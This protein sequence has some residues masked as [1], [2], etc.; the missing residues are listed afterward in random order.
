[1]SGIV[2][3]VNLGGAPVDGD[4]V[5][6]LTDFMS[7]RGPDA[8]EVW[9]DRHVGL[10]HTLLRTTYE[11]EHESQPATLDGKVW[12]VADARLDARSELVRKLPSSLI[13]KSNL[14]DAELILYAYETWGGECINYL[15]GDFA[16]AIWDCRNQRLFCA[17]DHLGVKPFFYAHVA[18]SFIFSNTLNAL[19]LDR[20]VSDELNEEAI[21]DYLLFGLNQDLSTTTFRDIRRLAA[22]HTLTVSD[23]NVKT[24]CYWTPTS[25]REV[26]FQDSQSYVERFDE[27]LSS[28]VDD[29]LRSDRAAISM[30]GGLDSTSIAAVAHERLKNANSLR[31]VS[32]VYDN[33]IPDEERQYSQATADHI[34]IPITHINGDDFS[35]FNDQ[36]PG[37]MDQA[38]PFLISALAGQFNTLMR[39]SADHSRVAL[40]GWDGDA[41]MNEPAN[42]YFESAARELRFKDFMLGLA[43]YISIQRSVR[44]LGI[45]RSIN[46]LLG[47]Q[48]SAS[49]FPD[50]I[51]ASFAKRTNLYE[52]A[53]QSSRIK[54]KPTETRPAALQALASKV[55]A[56]LFE[57]Y[58]PGA[59]KLPLEVRHPFIDVR[60][61]E[62]LMSIPAVPWFV[63][64]HI[65]RVAMRT[66]LPATVLNRRKTP[67]AGSPALQIIRR[68]SVRWLD[69]FEV[70]PKL[71]CF[72]NLK[73]RA[74][75]EDE[76]TS[77]SLW[78][79]LR[80]FALNHWLSNSQPID[81]VKSRQPTSSKEPAIQTS[82]A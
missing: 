72:V 58:D 19:R 40:T 5:W 32:V 79:N 76:Q 23:A 30:S 9:I 77:E 49:F 59:T 53:K 55:W 54:L 14:S 70:S 7:Y 56:P 74:A 29:R 25:T 3:M 51:D 37:D 1:M 68:G 16:F 27:L 33:L 47:E 52:R 15:I 6:R 45:R 67:L 44:G 43:C 17:R 46:R 75:I 57:G 8:Q 10:G 62:F 50:W 65:L 38:E 26:R 12:L 82:I 80:V 69:T 36:A 31:A 42:S 34:G 22:G 24:K 66:R 11:A 63:N 20:R 71:R 2:G 13:S 39:V 18:N 21:G 73:Q 35:L 78:A 41:L 61:I 64:K 60:L 81:R 4:L 48:D 28:A